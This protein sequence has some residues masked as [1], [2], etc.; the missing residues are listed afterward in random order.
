MGEIFGTP[1]H[2]LLIHIPVVVLPLL[3]IGA[4]VLAAKPSWRSRFSWA[5]A[6]ATLATAA[7]TFWATQSGKRLRD[8]LQPSLGSLAERHAELGDQTALLATAFFIGAACL[9]VMDRWVLPRR[10]AKLWPVVFAIVVALVGV[11]SAVW[12]IRTGH[13]GARITWKGVDV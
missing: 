4:I 2:P 10:P 7:V 3:A 13:E 9:V 11:A 1:A 6:G 8:A 12:V 5:L